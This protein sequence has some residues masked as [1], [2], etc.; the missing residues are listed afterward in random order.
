MPNLVPVSLVAVGRHLPGAVRVPA[1]RARRA[2][3]A[4]EPRR[5]R[6]P[7]ARVR[8]PLVGAAARR[9]GD[10]HR[11]PR[12]HDAR[13]AALRAQ[14]VGAAVARRTRAASTIA[15]ASRSSTATARPSSAARSSAGARPTGRSS[16]RRSSARSAART[17]LRGP[18]ARRRRCIGAPTRSASSRSGPT[19]GAARRRR[20][21]TDRVTAD[22]WLRTGDLARIDDDGF[23]WIEGRVS[24]MVNR[25]GLKVFPDEVEEHLRAHA[26]V[27]DAAVVGVRRRPARRSAVGVRRAAPARR[28]TPTRSQAWCR[29]AHGAL[30]GPGRASRWSTS[31]PRNEI[32]KVLR[33]DLVPLARPG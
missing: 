19:S 20:A 13:A 31:C 29:A 6:A 23:V 22:G 27:A 21:A 12:R 5:V 11:R 1:R 4:F 17:R 26:G 9:D 30:Q 18:R 33:Q 8:H 28:S 24:A 10:A 32:G 16:A 25:G 2:H 15:S 3:G 14:R 7:R